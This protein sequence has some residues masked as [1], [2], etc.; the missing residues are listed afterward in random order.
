MIG[1][2]AL[3]VLIATTG[4]T[5]QDSPRPTR[6][7]GYLNLPNGD[8]MRY[9]VLLPKATG[10]FPVLVEYDGYSAGSDP[11]MGKRWLR[12]GYAIVGINV[13]GTGCSTGDNKV[14]DSSVGAAGKHAVEWAA[15]QS[16]STGR[17]G[18]I[19]ASYSGITQLW[20]ALHRPKGLVAITP[21]KAVA[22]AYRDVGYPGGIPNIGFPYMW[23]SMFPSIWKDA[24]KTAAK[25]DGDKA[26]HR[27]VLANTT[28]ATRPDIDLSVLL[29]N[30]P[31]DNAMHRGKS[32]VEKTHR[33]KVPALFLQ[34]WQDEQV[35]PRA[36][37][38]EETIDPKNRWLLGSNGDHHTDLGARHID[39]TLK[40]FFAR[41]VKGEDNG[42]ENGPRVRLLQ[43]LSNARQ[44]EPTAVAEFDR[45]PVPVRPK[46]LWL[47]EGGRMSDQ[48]PTEAKAGASY[49]YP[50]ESPVVNDPANEGWQPVRDKKGQLTF[51]TGA[52]PQDLGFYGDGSADL[53]LSATAPDTDVQVTL[54]EVRPDGQEMFVQRGWLRASKRVLDKSR[55]TELRPYGDFRASAVKPLVPGRP[56]LL[57]MEIQRFAHVFRAGSSI[58]LTVDTPSQTG[59]WR[60]GHVKQHSTNTIWLDRGR[61]SSIV[62]G[63]VDYPHAESLPGCGT[64]M[65][66]PCRPNTTPVPQG[67]GPTP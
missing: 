32:S 35:G 16:W 47:H 14:F 3:A 61:P 57:R 52:L 26:C 18:M 19:G 50:V 15:K 7:W 53:W 40:Q 33:I 29:K 23:W 62:L 46:R 27:T 25:L 22:D 31:H 11:A 1:H 56:A 17:V 58:R 42:F 2:L 21:S 6:H 64:T 36:G 60:F 41:F 10:R 49:R 51:T 28:K 13:P 65:R 45:L 66:Q 9:S 37:Y 8:K 20:T 12:E 24:A 63:H 48:K 4:T 44:H 67:D 30:N 34:S 43:E 59:Y 38:A 5:V 54:S 39:D 55:S